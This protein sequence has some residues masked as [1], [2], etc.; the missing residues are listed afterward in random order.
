[1][2]SSAEKIQI[3]EC[4]GVDHR[5][6]PGDFVVESGPSIQLNDVT[7]RTFVEDTK[8]K[9]TNCYC[10][11]KYGNQNYV[12]VVRTILGVRARGEAADTSLYIFGVRNLF[13]DPQHQAHVITSPQDVKEAARQPP[14]GRGAHAAAQRESYRASRARAAA[15]NRIRFTWMYADKNR[16]AN[17]AAAQGEFVSIEDVKL[18]NPILVPVTCRRTAAILPGQYYVVDISARITPDDIYA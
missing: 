13:T 14:R 12:A 7:F 15:R 17:R 4:A 8:H 6:R 5:N 9:Y 10:F 18:T 16:S 2:C 11:T 1:M 3:L